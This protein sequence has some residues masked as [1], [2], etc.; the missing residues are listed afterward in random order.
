MIN[1]ALIAQN[2][3]QKHTNKAFKMVSRY[4]TVLAVLIIFMVR[5]VLVCEMER[6][7]LFLCWFRQFIGLT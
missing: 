5:F 4:V 7:V 6:F 3:T 1:L 2:E